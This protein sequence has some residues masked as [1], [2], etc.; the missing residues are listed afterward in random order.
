MV[1]LRDMESELG[2]VWVAGWVSE[3]E[4]GWGSA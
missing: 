3:W 2:W 1:R 4:L